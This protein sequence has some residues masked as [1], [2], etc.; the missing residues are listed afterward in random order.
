MWGSSLTVCPML[1]KV[2][3]KKNIWHW[4]EFL[5]FSKIRSCLLGPLSLSLS[6]ESP[7]SMSLWPL[8]YNNVFH[9]TPCLLSLSLSL[10]QVFFCISWAKPID[11]DGWVFFPN[12][13]T[14]AILNIFDRFEAKI[15]S[16]WL[17]PKV[18]YLF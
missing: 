14:I 13:T 2:T 1:F 3:K 12:W 17:T 4:I 11:T 18:L 7:S 15:G 16:G 8:L 10:S 6:L 5:G 9:T